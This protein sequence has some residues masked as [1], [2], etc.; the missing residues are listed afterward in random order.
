LIKSRGGKKK[1]FC[2]YPIYV[3]RGEVVLLGVDG[4]PCGEKPW[5][6]TVDFQFDETREQAFFGRR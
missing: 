1:A 4:V 2:N 6:L 3:P 5:A